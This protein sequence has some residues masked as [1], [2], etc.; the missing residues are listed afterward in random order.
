MQNIKSNLDANGTLVVNAKNF[1]L[2]QTDSVLVIKGLTN[3]HLSFNTL[4]GDYYS[5]TGFDEK[6]NKYEVYWAILDDFDA[7]H[8]DDESHACDWDNPWK[9]ELI[10]EA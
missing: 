4:Y 3:V 7:N 1:G 2:S 6:G 10:E 5:D 9:I 8:D